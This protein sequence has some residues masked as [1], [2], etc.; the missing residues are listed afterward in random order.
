MSYP[1]Y[2][3]PLIDFLADAYRFF[4]KHEHCDTQEL[5]DESITADMVEQRR[6]TPIPPAKNPSRYF[7]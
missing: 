5:P 1:R 3:V 2:K 7:R 4:E 6:T